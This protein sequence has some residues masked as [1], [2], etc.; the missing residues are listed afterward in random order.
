MTS[1]FPG[2]NDVFNEPSA[3]STTPLGDDGGSGRDMPENHDDLG[4]AIMAM[5]AEATLLVHSHDGTT[6]RHGSKLL[7]ANT[8]ES[9]DTD[10][11]ATAL[12]HTIGT[13]ANQGA[14]GNHSHG[15]V[16]V[17]PVGAIFIT[18]VAG[19]PAD[20]PHSLP[21]VWSQFADGRFIVAAGSTFTAGSTGGSLSHTHSATFQTTGGHS[22]TSPNTGSDGSHSHSSSG[23][24]GSSTYGHGHG[25]SSGPSGTES[26]WSSGGN[27][28]STTSHTHDTSGDTSNNTSHSHSVGSTSSDSA[29]Q[30][31]VASADSEADHTHT[32]TVT[33]DNVLPPYLAVYVWKRDS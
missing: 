5:Q 11:G 10:S 12:H 22:H 17:W 33:T 23:N 25:T 27:T 26:V 21:G 6:A 14:A 31:T 28:A 24:T 15:A 8:H 4:A 32:S 9:P 7:Q 2:A 19:N 20:P 30:H 3:P 18:E 1:A 13:G 29:H 16:V